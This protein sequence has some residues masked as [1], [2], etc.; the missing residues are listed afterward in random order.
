MIKSNYNT[1]QTNNLRI[2]ENQN[3][4]L[5]NK[6]KV[7]RT[8]E[9]FNNIK[10]LVKKLKKKKSEQEKLIIIEGKHKIG[11]YLL[12]YLGLKIQRQ[13]SIVLRTW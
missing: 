1:I 10:D 12:R 3:K 6:I 4:L 11:L 8:M 9:H 13:N 5:K 2:R 7:D